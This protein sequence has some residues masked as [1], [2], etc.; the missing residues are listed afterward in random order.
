MEAARRQRQPTGMSLNGRRWG[1]AY[2]YWMSREPGRPSIR[3][4]I[5]SM[6]PCASSRVIDSKGKDDTTV[7]GLCFSM[8]RASSRVAQQLGKAGVPFNHH[9]AV[10][11][12]QR[13]QQGAGNGAGASPH[14]DQ[15]PGRGPHDLMQDGLRQRFGGRG[16]GPDPPWIAQ[17]PHRKSQSLP[18]AVPFRVVVTRRVAQ[19]KARCLW[20][21]RRC[22]AH[23]NSTMGWSTTSDSPL[24]ASTLPT[25]PSAAANNTFSIF[26]ASITA[27][28]SPAC[29]F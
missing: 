6:Q 16:D 27:T 9:E 24:A 17:I 8:S 3:A 11:L 21:I 22:R 13:G 10:H 14:L 1:D 7:T 15:G 28:R 18:H 4:T 2:V 26:M 20:G 19:F 23:S 25:T 12:P 29:T 5:A